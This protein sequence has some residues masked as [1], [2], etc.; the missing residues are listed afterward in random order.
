MIRD[1]H[2]RAEEDHLIK[3]RRSS[4]YDENNVR[5]LIVLAT[6]HLNRHIS[7]RDIKKQSD[8]PRHTALRILKSLNFHPYHITLTQ[9]LLPN[10]FR[11]CR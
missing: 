3:Q 2:S 8:I 5:V 4:N 9:A 1:I 10:N 11:K 6:I 7:S